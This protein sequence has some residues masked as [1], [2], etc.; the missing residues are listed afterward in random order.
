MSFHPAHYPP[1]FEANIFGNFFDTIR[2]ETSIR[3]PLFL[4]NKK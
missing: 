1:V 2:S 4:E 3:D